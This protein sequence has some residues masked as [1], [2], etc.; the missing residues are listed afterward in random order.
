[1]AEPVPLTAD[2]KQ[3]G[4]PVAVSNVDDVVVVAAEGGDLGVDARS[5][6]VR[7]RE[8]RDRLVF[9]PVLD[10]DAIDV[11]NGSPVWVGTGDRL[12]IGWTGSHLRLLDVTDGSIEG[13]VGLEP[14]EGRSA[15][16]IGLDAIAILR[17]GGTIAAYGYDTLGPLWETDA[18]P[19]ATGLAAVDGGLVVVDP[20]G[21]HG[22]VGEG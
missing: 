2:G 22:L 17:A 12:L 19:E 9:D 4:R 3:L 11:A 21:L 1:V 15:L 16:A 5:G 13:E 6:T 20:A 18:Y 7:W 14:I 8:A 10:V